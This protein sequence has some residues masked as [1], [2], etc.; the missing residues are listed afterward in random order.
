MLRE[1]VLGVTVKMGR[2][3]KND[4]IDLDLDLDLDLG[5]DLDL[6]LDLD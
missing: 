5:L 6:D 4:W 3:R 2:E 1:G